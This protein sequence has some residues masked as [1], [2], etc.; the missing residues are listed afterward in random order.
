MA[1]ERDANGVPILGTTKPEGALTLASLVIGACCIAEVMQFRVQTATFGDNQ[2]LAMTFANYLD[3]IDTQPAT[4]E[5]SET[6]ANAIDTVKA[7]VDAAEQLGMKMRLR[8][9]KESGSKTDRGE[10]NG[11]E[12][13]P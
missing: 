13:N 4:R 2:L 3:V 9:Y 7:A 12:Q 1:L 6:L 11:R 8:A 5:M 10:E